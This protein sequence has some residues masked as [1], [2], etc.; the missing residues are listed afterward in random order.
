ME[1]GA[2]NSIQLHIV[3]F[4][5]S[6]EKCSCV[7]DERDNFSICQ[8][9]LIRVRRKIWEA[10]RKIYFRHFPPHVSVNHICTYNFSDS[11]NEMYCDG[12]YQ[13]RFQLSYHLE[14]YKVNI[15]LLNDQTLEKYHESENLRMLKRKQ[16]VGNERT[17]LYCL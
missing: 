13:W 15:K 17:K 16:E 6:Y 14:I 1:N 7:H 4:N 11:N 10:A 8:L 9:F 12:S 3:I 5:V 2:Q